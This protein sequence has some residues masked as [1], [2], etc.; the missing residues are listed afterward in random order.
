MAYLGLMFPRVMYT[1][2]YCFISGCGFIGRNLVYHL[3]TN[4]VTDKVSTN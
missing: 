2:I 1:S 4:N 3:L